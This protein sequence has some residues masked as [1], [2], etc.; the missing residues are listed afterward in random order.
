MDTKTVILGQVVPISW[1]LLQ[2]SDKMVVIL[3]LA[4]IYLTYRFLVVLVLILDFINL[5]LDTKSTIPG[6][7]VH[8]SWLFLEFSDKMATIMDFAWLAALD[9]VTTIFLCHIS[10]LGEVLSVLCKL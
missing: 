1:L 5:H 8:A 6:E 10:L 9:G 2:I 7:L 3:D 4:T